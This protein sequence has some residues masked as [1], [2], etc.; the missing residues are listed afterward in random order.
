MVSTT[1]ALLFLLLAGCEG[2]MHAPDAGA[3]DSGGST[4]EGVA[5][6]APVTFPS[7]VC[8]RGWLSV[9]LESGHACA[10]WDALPACEA[11]EL[12]SPG[13]GCVPLATDCGSDT[14]PE[15]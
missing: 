2:V 13:A 12:L 1:R 14:P 9:P 4:P 11:G 8:P 5:P 10:P 3:P 6:P 15:L 7:R